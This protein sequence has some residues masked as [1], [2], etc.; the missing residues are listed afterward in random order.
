MNKEKEVISFKKWEILLATLSTDT[1]G[2][3]ES[4][5]LPRALEHSKI[6]FTKDHLSLITGN[7]RVLIE[8]NKKYSEKLKRK[9]K[10]NRNQK[11]S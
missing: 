3:Y 9:Q 8:G 2:L 11:F 1:H 4:A 6:T 5:F 10:N 7:R